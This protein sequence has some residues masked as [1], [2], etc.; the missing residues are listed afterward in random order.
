MRAILYVRGPKT[1][2]FPKDLT[3]PLQLN[4]LKRFCKRRHWHVVNQFVDITKATGRHPRPA[5][6]EMMEVALERDSGIDVVLVYSPDRL[7]R[8]VL[9]LVRFSNS[10][11]S[12]GRK[13]VF[14]KLETNADSIGGLI[15]ITHK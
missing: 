5:R 4:H 3:V 9:T 13:L 15:D 6:A 1:K 10:L 7:F 2:I 12:L 11:K 8:D 14:S